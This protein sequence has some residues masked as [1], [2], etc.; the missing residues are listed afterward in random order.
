MTS[1]TLVT[2]KDAKKHT[3]CPRLPEADSFRSTADHR[4]RKTRATPSD[5]SS[6]FSGEPPLHSSDG[7]GEQTADL[8]LL[9]FLS[10]VTQPEQA[11]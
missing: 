3:P 1:L 4:A 11:L 6:L 5:S 2:R 8:E 9:L 10:P 7:K